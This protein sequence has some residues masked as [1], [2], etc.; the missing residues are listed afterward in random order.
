MVAFAVL[1]RPGFEEPGQ[2]AR[3]LGIGSRSE[4]SPDVGEL[5]RLCADAL[6]LGRR[7]D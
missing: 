4:F 7:I 6:T 3:A 1:S 5:L 2:I